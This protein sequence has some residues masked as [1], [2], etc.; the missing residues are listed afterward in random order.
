[1]RVWAALTIVAV[2]AI[3]GTLVAGDPRTGAFAA[4]RMPAWSPPLWAW[5]AI[6]LLYYAMMVTVLVRAGQGLALVLLLLVL[7]G[8]EGWNV[9]LF[10]LGRTDLAF[11]TLWPFLLLVLIAAWACGRRDRLS[12]AL[13]LVYAL[14]LGFDL[15]WT[16]ALVRLNPA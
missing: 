7:A 12:G 10:R 8:N 6:G 2:A 16:A 11:W 5:L 3:G 1:M 9:F 15:A 13:L 4:L 14:W